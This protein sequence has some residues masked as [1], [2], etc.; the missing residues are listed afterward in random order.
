MKAD[1]EDQ[2]APTQSPSRGLSLANYGYIR[3]SSCAGLVDDDLTKV[4]DEVER[5]RIQNRIA[6]RN[7]RMWPSISYILL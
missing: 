3:V 2:A 5:R 6:Q 4:V 7:Y 1:E